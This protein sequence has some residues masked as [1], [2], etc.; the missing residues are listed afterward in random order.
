[1]KRPF[2]F[3]PTALLL[4]SSLEL[5]AQHHWAMAFIENGNEK[6]TITEYHSVLEKA[7]NE[8]EYYR[9]FDDG[10]CV[11][12]E[13]YNPV[14]LQYGY[15]WADKQMYIYDF[16]SNKENIAFDFNLSEGDHFTT[17]NGI[18]WEVVMV[19]D[20]LVNMSFCG[21]EECVTKRLLTVKTLDGTQYDQWLE[22]FGSFS[23][24]FMINSMEDVEYSQTLWMEYGMGEYIAREISTDP[25]YTHDS[26]WLDGA[27][28]A[29][30]MPYTVCTYSDGQLTIEDVQWWY[31]HRDYSCFYREGDSIYR[32]YC[33]ELE[34]HVDL[35]NSALRR[36]VITFNGLPAP[37]S[38]KYTVYVDDNEFTTSMGNIKAASQYSGYTY[39]LQGR[40]I[41]SRAAKGIYIKEGK[42]VYVK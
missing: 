23:S 9:I 32:V 42:K 36:N 24:H 22:D 8:M 27:F 28:E 39:D 13:A 19:K 26:G 6:P 14:K 1:M 18:E 4:A 38:G 12:D 37:G 34:P 10:H 16:E 41:K 3:L 30:V 21:K 17:I 5:Y 33:W 31:E 29:S 7:D 2:H 11:G 25:I 20:T 35:G 15:R 40:E